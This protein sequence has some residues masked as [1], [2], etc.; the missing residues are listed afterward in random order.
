MEC[1]KIKI[2]I[3][4]REENIKYKRDRERKG[5]EKGRV[6]GKERNVN[7]SVRIH[8]NIISTDF[9]CSRACNYKVRTRFLNRNSNDCAIVKLVHASKPIS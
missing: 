4:K 5:K 2:K 3:R 6:R 7:L 1:L 9:S 8:S